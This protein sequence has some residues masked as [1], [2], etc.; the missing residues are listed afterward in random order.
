[1][2]NLIVRANI[3]RYLELLTSDDLP[4][5]ELSAI[6]KALIAEESKLSYDLEQLSFAESRAAACRAR[7]K[8]LRRL[9]DGFARDA[10]GRV[11]AD[12]LL[13]NFETTLGHVEHR[14]RV[15][16]KRVR[17]SSLSH[18]DEQR[19][20]LSYRNVSYSIVRTEDDV[21]RWEFRVGHQTKSG[22]TRAALSLLA[23]RRVQMII[24]REL[25]SSEAD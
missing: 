7:L 16:R 9:R 15:M 5:E 11:Q 8:D 24:D 1:M 18:A 19:R 13:A 22:K 25:R 12:A 21:W 10:A 3:D 6:S 4:A 2:N 23:E 20:S 14:C 17:S